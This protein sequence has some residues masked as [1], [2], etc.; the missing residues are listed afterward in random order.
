MPIPTKRLGTGFELP[1]YGLGTW[2]MGGRFQRD[3]E[4]DDARDVRAIEAAIEAGV[5]HIDT[6]EAYAAGHTEKLVGR[7]IRRHDRERLFLASKVGLSQ[8]PRDKKVIETAEQSLRRLGTDYLDLYLLHRFNSQVPL[9]ETM[10]ALDSLVERGLVRHLGVS[11]FSEERFQAAQRHTAHKLVTNQ[12]HYNLEIREMETAGVLDF[13][14]RSDVML[15][16]WRPL[17]KGMLLR[18]DTP[19]VSELAAKYEKSP[20]QIA[21]NWLTS[22]D[23]VVTLAKT[24]TSEHLWENLGALG[25]R[26]DPD[27]IERLRREFPDQQHVSDAVPLDHG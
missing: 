25:W 18:N 6:A 8:P 13:C 3:A 14:Q 10:A 16:A 17:Q 15:V 19:I 7:A 11:N 9:G 1:V 20:A 4:N 2:Q 5:T 22:Q 21:I 26:L 27:D 12:V 24:S 23:N